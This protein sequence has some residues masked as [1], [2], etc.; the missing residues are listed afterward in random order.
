MNKLQCHASYR[1]YYKVYV[2]DPLLMRISNRVKIPY[3]IL[4]VDVGR[5]LITSTVFDNIKYN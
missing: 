1:K 2:Y 3:D 4:F 5:H